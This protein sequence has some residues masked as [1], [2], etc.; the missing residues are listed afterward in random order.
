M[1]RIKKRWDRGG[2]WLAVTLTMTFG[3]VDAA[4]M[5]YQDAVMLASPILYFQ[6]NE[7]NNIIINHGSLGSSHNALVNGSPVQQVPTSE[8]DTGLLFDS[9]DD[10]VETF[11]PSPLTLSLNPSFSAEALL[12]IPIGGFAV[13]WAPIMHWGDGNTDR[14][15]REVY[16]GFQRHNVNK[17]YAGF[18]NGGVRTVNPLT[19]GRWY[20]IVMVRQAGGSSAIGTQI[21]ID[22]KQ[23]LTEV[24]T[25]LNPAVVAPNVNSTGMRVNRARDLTRYFSATLDE[26][27]VYDRVL[28][29][30]EI[31]D[32]F[33]TIGT[34]CAARP[35]SDSNIDCKVDLLDFYIMASEWLD[36]GLQ[37][38]LDC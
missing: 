33:A 34:L 28:T 9:V 18:Y 19:L 17:I 21:Y 35:L 12:F 1:K 23:V 10:F 29:A 26:L 36:C 22:G 2:F 14:D 7:P 11:S 13:N 25:D 20:H 27:A 37:D 32:R 6:F 8:G 15:G 38:S 5:E 30:Q 31:Q 4:P 24:D 3:S 16:F